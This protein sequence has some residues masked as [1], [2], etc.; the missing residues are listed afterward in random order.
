MNNDMLFGF[1]FK[2]FVTCKEYDDVMYDP[3]KSFD[4]LSLSLSELILILSHNILVFYLCF[5]C[6]LASR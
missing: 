6:I 3:I 4:S 5:Y 1:W 2:K